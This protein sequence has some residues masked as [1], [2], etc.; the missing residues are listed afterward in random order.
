[1]KYYYVVY[2]DSIGE[3]GEVLETYEEAEQYHSEWL[4]DLSSSEQRAHNS[5][6]IKLHTTDKGDVVGGETVFVWEGDNV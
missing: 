4:N 3:V 5:Y 6:I 1:M 2:V